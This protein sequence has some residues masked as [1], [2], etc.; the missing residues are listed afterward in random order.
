MNWRDHITADPAVL[1]G[2]PVIRGTRLAVE[3]VLGLIAQGWG[4]QEIVRN[5]FDRA[6]ARPWGLCSSGSPNLPRL[7]WLHASRD[8]WAGHFSVVD[9]STIR[10]RRLPG[11]KTQRPATTHPQDVQGELT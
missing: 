2:K 5:S 10:T 1:V 8:D 11:A 9:D 3:F 6:E 7:P 4:E